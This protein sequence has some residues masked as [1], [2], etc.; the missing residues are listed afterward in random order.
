MTDAELY[1]SR[2]VAR[3]LA[4]EEARSRAQLEFVEFFEDEG[5]TVSSGWGSG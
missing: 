5:G 4:L 3:V 1:G 2:Y